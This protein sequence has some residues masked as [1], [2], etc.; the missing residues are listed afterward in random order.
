MCFCRVLVSSPLNLQTLAKM[1]TS[2]KRYALRSMTLE[3]AGF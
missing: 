1:E 3:L 2:V